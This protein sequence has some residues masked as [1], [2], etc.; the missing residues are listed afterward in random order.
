IRQQHGQTVNTDAEA[1]RGRKTE[2]QYSNI[3]V[4]RQRGFFITTL[5]LLGLGLEETVLGERVVQLAERVSDFTSGDIGL[6]SFSKARI[7]RV[8]LCK[9]RNVGRQI[10]YMNRLDQFIFNSLTKHGF[11]NLAP[12]V[13][14]LYFNA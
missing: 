8:W 7:F 6:E 9:G 12:R 11:N 1:A 4:I 10:G 2:L 5:A 13:G 14:C 3:I